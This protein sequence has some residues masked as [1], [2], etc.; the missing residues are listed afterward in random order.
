MRKKLENKGFTLV[1][2]LAVIII[3]C[4]TVTIVIVQVDK[5]IND[6][7]K[8]GNDVQI[9]TIENTAL[10]YTEEYRSNLTNINEKKVDTVSLETLINSGL[11]EEKNLKNIEKDDVVLIAEINNEIKTKYTKTSKNVIFLNGPS[12]ISIYLGDEYQEMGGYVAIPGTGVIKLTERSFSS[13]I[14]NNEVGEYKVT[15]SYINTD[16]V[17]RIVSVIN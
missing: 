10:L 2:L 5:N 13:N 6:V 1:E 14:N 8:F 16:S 15:Y 11:L 12:E 4:I 3:L 7:N 9:K 17:E